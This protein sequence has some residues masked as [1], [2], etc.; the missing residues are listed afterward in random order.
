[1]KERIKTT[2]GKRKRNHTAINKGKEKKGVKGER[3]G[4]TLM[5]SP[6]EPISL[7]AFWLNQ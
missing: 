2:K 1:M 4:Y 3:S 6:M 7:L 5:S